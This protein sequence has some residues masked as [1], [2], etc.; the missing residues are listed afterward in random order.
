MSRI[1]S[2]WGLLREA[3]EGEH[4]KRMNAILHTCDDDQFCINYFKLLEFV[5]PKLQRAE[6]I[7]EAEEQVIRIVHVRSEAE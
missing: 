6:Q 1:K 4:S 7:R 3:I 2:E 5:K